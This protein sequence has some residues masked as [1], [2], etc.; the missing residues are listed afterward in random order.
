MTVRDSDSSSI[1]QVQLGV[2]CSLLLYDVSAVSFRRRQILLST[3]AGR[4]V[5]TPTPP[6]P[7]DVLHDHEL[8]LVA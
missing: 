6:S 5:P 3:Q 1:S 4:S 2:S 7:A 8:G